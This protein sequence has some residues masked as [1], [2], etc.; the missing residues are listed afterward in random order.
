VASGPTDRAW[1]DAN[2]FGKL[3]LDEGR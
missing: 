1:I 2:I 3:V